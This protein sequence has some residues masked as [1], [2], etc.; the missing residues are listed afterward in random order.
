MTATVLKT[1]RR[2][3]RSQL[4]DLLVGPHGI[5]RYLELIRPDLTVND[6][7]A[8]V[9]AVRRQTERSV[10]ITL[11]PNAAWTGFSAGQFV[12]VGVEIDGVR[13]TRTYS[14]ASSQHLA[15]GTFELT[16]TVHPQGL[17]SRHLQQQ[18]RP[19]TVLHLA[20]A[21]GEF[22]LPTSRPE[23][24]VLISG[25]SGITPVISMLRTLCDEGHAGEIA[26]IHYARTKYDWLYRNEVARLAENHENLRVSYLATRQGPGARL[27]RQALESLLPGFS[28]E[29]FTAAVCGP[30]SLID[31]TRTIWADK[32]ERVLAESF[33]PPTLSVSGAAADGTL[34]FSRSEL[35]APIGEGTLLEQAEAAGLS[36]EFGC[37]MGICHTCTCRKTAGAVQNILTGEVSEEEDEDIQLCVSVPAGDVALEI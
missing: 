14:P 16:V 17:V 7:R 9:L 23:R 13:R 11:R 2:L 19:G 32:P 21:Q 30:Q 8:E 24:L 18:V 28:P 31:A 15:D 22:V 34:R 20:E 27:E 29:H 37:R 12:R 36:P 26:F 35:S 6:P 3:L 5:D 33:E 25:G 1:P 4:V 10:T